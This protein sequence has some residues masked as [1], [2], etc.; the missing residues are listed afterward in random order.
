MTS[1]ELIEGITDPYVMSNDFGYAQTD[2]DHIAF[3]FAGLAELGDMCAL[4]GNAFYT[5]PDM[6]YLVQRI[7][8]NAVAPSGH[9]PCLP[10]PA[11]HVYFNTAPVLNDAVTITSQGQSGQTK[12]VHIPVGQ[13]G[14]VELDLFSEAPTSGPWTVSVKELDGSNLDLSLDQKSGQN[15][16]KLTL[17]IHVRAKNA[18]YGAELFLVESTLGTDRNLWLGFVGN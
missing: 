9:E 14:T 8:S 10:Q 6:P 11:G 3:T 7:W 13:T 12:G 18:D 16:D 15:G 5:P 4:V 2:D 1:H 17:T